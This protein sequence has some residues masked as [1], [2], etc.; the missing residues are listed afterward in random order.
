MAGDWIKVDCTTPDK[1]EMVSLANAL[2]IDQDAAVG[3]CLRVWIWADQQ[4]TNGNAISVTES[5]LDRITYCKGFAAAMKSVGWLVVDGEKLT[6]PHF[7][8]HN[9]QTAK[10]RALTRDR[11]KSSRSKR[12][13]CNDDSVTASLPEI[14]KRRDREENKPPLSIVPSREI[15]IPEKMQTP[16]VQQRAAMWFAHLDVSHPDKRP[17]PDSPQMQAFWEIANR[18]GPERFCNAVLFSV[19]SG[20]A[21][22][23]EQSDQ[24]K[25]PQ[26]NQSGPRRN[27]NGKLI[28][29]MPTEW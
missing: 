1:P 9:G 23:R 11:V 15:L 21:N 4:S 16:E 3:K 19:G 18:M 2:G 17:I 25:Q 6:L 8:R 5:F 13:N 26:P 24:Q 29:E 14:E 10:T 27:R 12:D 22:L 7:D 28:Q 20:F